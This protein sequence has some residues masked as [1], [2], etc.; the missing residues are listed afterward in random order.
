[1]DGIYTVP[2]NK[3]GYLSFCGIALPKQ[4]GYQSIPAERIVLQLMIVAE[5]FNTGR[6]RRMRF[7]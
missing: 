1:M 4:T 2:Q 7:P 5:Q 6:E 3:S